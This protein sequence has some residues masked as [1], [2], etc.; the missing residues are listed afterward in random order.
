MLKERKIELNPPETEI[1]ISI[2]PKT[3]TKKG[4]KSCI[5]L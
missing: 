5:T 1:L 4:I 3:K 2:I